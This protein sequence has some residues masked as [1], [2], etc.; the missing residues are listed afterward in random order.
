[1]NSPLGHAPVPK[2][3]A[4]HRS[5]R[6]ENA[7]PK[8]RSGAPG[9][10]NGTQRNRLFSAAVPLLKGQESPVKQPDSGSIAPSVAVATIPSVLDFMVHLCS[11]SGAQS[12][13]SS[14]SWWKEAGLGVGEP[15]ERRKR[16]NPGG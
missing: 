2:N 12:K 9:D 11:D 14:G 4:V 15:A 8:G 1:M 5:H 10:P 16:P 7:A 3:S 6:A 13:G